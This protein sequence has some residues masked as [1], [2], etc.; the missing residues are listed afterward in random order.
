MKGV[1]LFHAKKPALDGKNLLSFNK[2]GDRPFEKMVAVAKKEGS[3]WV[4][5][6][7]PYPGTEQIREKTSY[8][9]TN[10]QGFFCGVGAYK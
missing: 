5:Y 4:D 8:I 7:W 2:Y 1:M 10:K 9:M 3:G 6:K